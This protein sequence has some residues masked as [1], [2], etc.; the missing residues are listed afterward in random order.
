MPSGGFLLASVIML[1]KKKDMLAFSWP[2]GF[3]DQQHTLA[4]I[5]MM[6]I[7]C[8]RTMSSAVYSLIAGSRALWRWFL[9]SVSGHR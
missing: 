5:A 4:A 1:I 2:T 3:D 7:I 8:A 9:H 6:V